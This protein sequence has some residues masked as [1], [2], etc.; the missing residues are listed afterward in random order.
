MLLAML[1]GRAIALMFTVALALAAPRLARGLRRFGESQR[2]R[3]GHDLT[4]RVPLGA[5][6]ALEF[7]AGAARHREEPRRRGLGRLRH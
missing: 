4:W 2:R 6:H 5:A 1:R 7:A 3:G